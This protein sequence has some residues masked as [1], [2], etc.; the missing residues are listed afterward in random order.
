MR[1][2]VG[3]PY[4]TD[5]V[6]PPL[7]INLPPAPLIGDS[8]EQFDEK[9]FPFAEAL[10]PWGQSLNALGVATKTNAVSAHESALASEGSAA[11]SAKSAEAAGITAGAGKWVSGKSYAEGAA[12]WSPMDFQTY[13]ARQSVASSVDPAADPTNW[14]SIGSSLA[15]L[16]AVSLSF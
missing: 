5:P 12:V 7:V 9:A 1:Y 3:E 6:N 15:Q 13:R 10:N 8:P 14:V 11:E 2:R 16:H 4:M